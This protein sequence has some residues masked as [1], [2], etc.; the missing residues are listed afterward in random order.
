MIYRLLISNVAFNETN[1]AYIYYE[2]QQNGLGE[3]F[4]K[5][6]EEA[7]YNLSHTPQHYGYIDTQKE[8]RDIKIRNFPFIIIFQIITNQV[9]ILRVFNTNR[10]PLSLKNL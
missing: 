5:S 3:R 7:Y 2:N 9:L 10:N 1:D 6:I 8:L 4:L